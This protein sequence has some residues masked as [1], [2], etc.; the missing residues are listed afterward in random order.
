MTNLAE[1]R[2]ADGRFAK[3]SKFVPFRMRSDAR[4]IWITCQGFGNKDHCHVSMSWTLWIISQG[5]RFFQ[6]W[7]S[8]HMFLLIDQCKGAPILSP[9]RFVEG[10]LRDAVGKQLS[11]IMGSNCKDESNCISCSVISSEDLLAFLS[12]WGDHRQILSCDARF[13]RRGIRDLYE[14][15]YGDDDMNWLIVSLL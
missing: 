4:E 9:G 10:S 15:R 14:S 11:W 13:E 5:Q 6:Q 1:G 3:K 8:L 7:G 2:G 12:I